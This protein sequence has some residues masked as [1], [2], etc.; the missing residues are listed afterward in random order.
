MMDAK[1][2]DKVW[3]NRQ[4]KIFEVFVYAVVDEADFRKTGVDRYYRVTAE[5]SYVGATFEKCPRVDADKVFPTKEA[6]IAALVAE[7][8]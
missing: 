3:V 8:N 7:N 6:A 1:V 2:Y 4:G 5:L